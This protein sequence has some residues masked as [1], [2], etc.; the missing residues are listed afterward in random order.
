MSLKISHLVPPIYSRVL[1]AYNALKLP[2]YY[3]I[4]S[5][6]SIRVHGGGR[7]DKGQGRREKGEG[8]R[9]KGEG[10]REKGKAVAAD[11]CGGKVKHHTSK[12]KHENEYK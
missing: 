10:R 5:F 6:G 12:E 8:T 3:W 4:P 1:L 9:D 11:L 7:R 2:G